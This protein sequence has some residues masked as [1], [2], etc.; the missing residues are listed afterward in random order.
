MKTL[1]MLFILPSLI[2]SQNY[3]LNS[4]M[5]KEFQNIKTNK[6]KSIKI[7]QSSAQYRTEFYNNE[8]ELTKIDY[9]DIGYVE[10]FKKDD[11]YYYKVIDKDLSIEENNNNIFEMNENFFIDRRWPFRQSNEEIHYILTDSQIKM[12]YAYMETEVYYD[13]FI[14]NSY[15][16]NMG[17]IEVVSPKDVVHNPVVLKRVLE[18]FYSERKYEE[19]PVLISERKYIYNSD[20][21]LIN[22]EVKDSKT[23]NIQNITLEYNEKGL[24]VVNEN[25]ET[26]VY[27]YY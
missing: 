4:Y 10:I 3:S 8:G 6:I 16:E 17:S 22:I 26:L 12:I 21:K 9:P 15:Y 5:D 13:V 23:N 2:F 27:E 24:P 1:L 11:R 14:Y 7:S 18:Y 20:F 25:G 19:L